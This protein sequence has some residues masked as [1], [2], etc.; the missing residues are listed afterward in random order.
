MILSM[1]HY[2]SMINKKDNKEEKV[3]TT[4]HNRNELLVNMIN[5]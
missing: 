4:H 3:K 5:L 1:N 2:Y